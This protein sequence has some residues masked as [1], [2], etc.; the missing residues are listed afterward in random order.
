M[1]W[2]DQIEHPWLTYVIQT[3]LGERIA[4]GAVF[5]EGQVTVDF[6]VVGSWSLSGARLMLGGLSRFPGVAS[7]MP[8]ALSNQLGALSG[9]L[10]AGTR[11]LVDKDGA[12]A[13]LVRTAVSWPRPA[14]PSAHEFANVV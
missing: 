7:W 1:N 6:A 3:P 9:M 2:L 4:R 12:A 5:R 13:R 11:V 10:R 8:S 14:R